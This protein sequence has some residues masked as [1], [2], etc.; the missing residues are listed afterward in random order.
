MVRVEKD[1]KTH[2]VPNPLPWAGY[3]PLDHVAQIISSLLLLIIISC[4]CLKSFVKTK[5]IQM[6]WQMFEK[7]SCINKVN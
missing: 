6:L 5:I 7:K 4:L 1:L 2:L 3:L